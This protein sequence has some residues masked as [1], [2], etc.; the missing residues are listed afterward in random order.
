M[1]ALA[2]PKTWSNSKPTSPSFRHSRPCISK[3]PYPRFSRATSGLRFYF[4]ETGRWLSRD[5][6]GE[7]GGVNLFVFVGNMPVDAVDPFGIT[8]W[9]VFAIGDSL[10]YG[11]GGGAITEWKSKT[12]YPVASWNGWKKGEE[13]P[14]LGGALGGVNYQGWLFRDCRNE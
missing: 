8:A 5:P 2:E 7:E 3:T 14:K 1:V 12:D 10:T 4:P 11:V 9:T 6:A 13:F